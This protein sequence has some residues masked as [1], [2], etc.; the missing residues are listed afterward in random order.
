MASPY[1]KES[2]QL[3]DWNITYF[4]YVIGKYGNVC[5]NIWEFSDTDKTIKSDMWKR[6]LK[7]CDYWKRIRELTK[8]F[9]TI[10]YVRYGV[11]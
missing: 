9:K 4:M 7:I 6:I 10:C 2:L 11:H 1:L 3:K 8:W 5:G